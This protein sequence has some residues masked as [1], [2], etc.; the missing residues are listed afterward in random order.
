MDIA[1]PVCESGDF[2]SWPDAMLSPQSRKAKTCVCWMPGAY[3]M[4]C[5]EL[6][7]L[8]APR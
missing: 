7:D 1:G 6:P 5:I 4:Y 2:L 3:G 8:A